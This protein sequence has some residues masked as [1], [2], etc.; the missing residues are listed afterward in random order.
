MPNNSVME[1]VIPAHAA[2]ATLALTLGAYNLLRK[3][4]GDRSHRVVG[5]VWVAMMYATVL[6][7]FSIR[8]LTPGRFSWIHGLSAFTF[9]TL[10]IALW[11]AMTGR[12]RTHQ[13]FVTGS[14]L[15]LVGAFI[16][17]VAVPVRYLPRNVVERPAEVAFALL[18]CIVVTIAIVR[19]SRADRSRVGGQA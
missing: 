10:T 3:S 16:G 18:G 1:W 5:R 15:G 8:E 7:S 2:V 13:R 9:I 12:I 19:A 14:Y 11:A 4:K 17:A 6:S